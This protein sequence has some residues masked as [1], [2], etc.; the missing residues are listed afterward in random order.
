VTSL[1]LQDDITPPS[2]APPIYTP[3]EVPEFLLGDDSGQID[4]NCDRLHSYQTIIVIHNRHI[5]IYISNIAESQEEK[6]VINGVFV[7]NLSKNQKDQYGSQ[8]DEDKSE[9]P[10]IFGESQR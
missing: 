2:S 6:P 10:D 9:A 7:I 5:Y 4:G 3:P 1:L 8:F